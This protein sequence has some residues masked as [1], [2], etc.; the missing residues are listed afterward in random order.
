M[1]NKKH[2]NIEIYSKKRKS[3]FKKDLTIFAIKAT[4]L[5]VAGY[6]VHNTYTNYS[7][8]N[9]SPEST[10]DRYIDCV[11]LGECEDITLKVDE[12]PKDN[13][14]SPN[15][16]NKHGELV[17]NADK[18]TKVSK[19][20]ELTTHKGVYINSAILKAIDDKFT[21]A[22]AK[23]LKV[24]ML[25]ECAKDYKI[26]GIAS[27]EC[28]SKTQNKNTN[29]TW[30]CGYLQINSKSPCTEKD[31]SI[32][33]QITMAYKKLNNIDGEV[34]GKWKCWSSYKFRDSKTITTSYHLWN[35]K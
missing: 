3:S 6:F 15:E 28:R 7:V 12:T 19:L 30:D 22:D 25:A 24:I 2:S 11:N 34:C 32:D 21:P 5:V 8:V 1:I 27:Y 23:K 14:Y 29:N 35:N 10:T 16:M 17:H 4:L 13:Y 31:Y 26:D 20:G 18:N 9:N 33:N